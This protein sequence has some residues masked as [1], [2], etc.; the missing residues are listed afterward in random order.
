M[1][2]ENMVDTE[3][4]TLEMEKSQTEQQFW[5]NKQRG[6]MSAEILLT[7]SVLI[8]GLIFIASNAPGI[9]YKINEIRFAWQADAIQSEAHAWKKFQPNFS[10]VTLPKLCTEANLSKSI[11]GPNDDGVATNP[12]GGNWSITPNSGNPSIVDVIATI[13]TDVDRIPQLANAVA[14]ATRDRCVEATGCATLTTTGNSIT[15]VY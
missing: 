2:T 5:R 13:P 3:V 9:M 10:N 8:V 12:F 11:C 1:K 6:A 14:P 7:V 15:L 4:D